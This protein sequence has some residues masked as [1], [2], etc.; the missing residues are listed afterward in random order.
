MWQRQSSNRQ[1]QRYVELHEGAPYRWNRVGDRARPHSS[2]VGPGEIASLKD[3]SSAGKLINPGSW[4]ANLNGGLSR[5]SL[6][7][8]LCHAHSD[9]S[10]HRR[11][12]RGDYKA[13]I[14]WVG[15]VWRP[16]RLER[17]A[18]QPATSIA[19]H[20]VRQHFLHPDQL[21][22]SAGRKYCMRRKRLWPAYAARDG[23]HDSISFF[24]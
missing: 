12:G 17:N 2:V 22:F 1:P 21:I 24:V 10:G 6:D 16:S 4:S 11:R 7:A 14:R 13:F 18:E 9:R 19:A 3:A 20:G 8:R 15:H 5:A 23:S